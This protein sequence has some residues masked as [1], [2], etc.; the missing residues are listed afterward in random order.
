M[1]KEVPQVVHQVEQNISNATNSIYAEFDQ[2]TYF[3][4]RARNTFNGNTC[5]DFSNCVTVTVNPQLNLVIPNDELC[6]GAN[7]AKLFKLL[8]VHQDIPTHGV[9][10]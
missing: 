7:Y 5:D 6:A 8:A 4:R 9:E 1:A 3:R 2:T 10:D